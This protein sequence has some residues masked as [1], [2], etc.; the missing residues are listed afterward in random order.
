LHPGFVATNFG[1]RNNG[2][3]G[4]A[5]RIAMLFAGKPEPGAT[6]IVYRRLRRAWCHAR[7]P[8]PFRGK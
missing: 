3:F 6:T 8:P 7:L 4:V 1:Q 2:L 5:V